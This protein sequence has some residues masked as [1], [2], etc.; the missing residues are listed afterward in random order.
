MEAKCFSSIDKAEKTCLL[1]DG[2]NISATAK[3]LEWKWI[4][5]L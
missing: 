1:I 5:R 2:A 4:G 3:A